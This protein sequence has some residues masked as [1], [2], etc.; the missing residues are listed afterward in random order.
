M[1]LRADNA[2][3]GLFSKGNVMQILSNTEV[4]AVS[5]QARVARDIWRSFSRVAV[6]S[7]ERSFLGGKPGERLWWY[8]R[9]AIKIGWL[10]LRMIVEDSGTDA[11]HNALT[12][13]LRR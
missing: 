10:V 6:G 2:L 8:R 1:S 13:I 9:S 12:A 5:T 7:K 3:T 11:E 4:S